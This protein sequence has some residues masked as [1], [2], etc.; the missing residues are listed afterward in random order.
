MM[1]SEPP[2]FTRPYDDRPIPQTHVGT[3]ERVSRAWGLSPADHETASVLEVGCANGVNLTAM[4]ARLPGAT[5]LGVDIDPAVV[6]SARSRAAEADLAN[7]RFEVGDVQTFDVQPGTFD[8]AIAHGVLSWVSEPVGTALFGLFRRALSVEGIAYVSFDAMPGAAL[9]ETLGL[10]LRGLE[11]E[12][13]EK[14][15]AVLRAL[16]AGAEPNTLQGAWLHSETT[17]ALGQP[18]S[19]IE[20]QFL[21]PHQRAL[22]VTEV[23]D[24][25]QAH[26]LRFVD[27]VAETG[28]VAETLAETV[29]AIA[30][31]AP[32]RRAAEQLLDTAIH[33]Q[34][35][36]SLFTRSAQPLVH[37]GKDVRPD[38]VRTEVS[39]RPRVLPL[40]RVEARTLG[41]VSTPELGHRALHPL[42]AL[43]LESL[44]GSR[45]I[46][47]LEALVVDHVE[48][49]H[50]SLPTESGEPATLQEAQ[51]G[52]SAVV[53]SALEDLAG[54]GILLPADEP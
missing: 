51:S 37:S 6:A 27:D 20:Q 31:V 40:S 47:E 24:V 52:A 4:A 49:G 44:D 14:V 53:A 19:F 50:L 30:T 46:A 16:Q 9:R 17:A 23:W 25:A 8:Y 48:K 15:R 34:F 39:A 11:T 18:A 2:M 3:L 35:R 7:V 38:S 33:R 26:G 10:G 29:R 13:V 41:F 1:Q 36:A 12:D 43:L 42:H 54:A 32:N 45:T 5:F 21:S 22:A 28:L